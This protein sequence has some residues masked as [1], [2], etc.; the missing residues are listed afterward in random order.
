MQPKARGETT[1]VMHRANIAR[2]LISPIEKVPA[3]MR[4]PSFGS[5][6][7]A[8]PPKGRSRDNDR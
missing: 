3:G 2:L 1:V 7:W 6:E 8:A 5:G 4:M